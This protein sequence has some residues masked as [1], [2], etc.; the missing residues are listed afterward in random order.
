MAWLLSK[1]AV[2]SPVFGATKAEQ[3]DDAVAAV[4]L[5]LSAEETARL[6]EPYRPHAA[7]EGYN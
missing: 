4:S 1:P 3:M 6:E 7:T 2:T 5:R